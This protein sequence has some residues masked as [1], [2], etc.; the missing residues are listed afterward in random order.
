VIY[1]FGENY[2]SFRADHSYFGDEFFCFEYWYGISIRS[3]SHT[4]SHIIR[5]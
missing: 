3:S 2:S 5:L 4:T 1:W